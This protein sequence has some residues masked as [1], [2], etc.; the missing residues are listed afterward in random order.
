[1]L[2]DQR[3]KGRGIQYF[4]VICIIFTYGIETKP[5]KYLLDCLCAIQGVRWYGTIGTRRR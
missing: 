2:Q 3:L 5:K 1:M 4:H